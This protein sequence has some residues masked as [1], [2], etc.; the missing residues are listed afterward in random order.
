MSFFSIYDVIYLLLIFFI[1]INW[2]FS[3]N[4]SLTSD[5]DATKNKSKKS[6]KKRKKDGKSKKKSKKTKKSKHKKE[7]QKKKR[8]KQKKK[9]VSSSSSGSS[10][11]SSDSESSDN[12]DEVWIEKSKVHEFKKPDGTKSSKSKKHGS[13]DDGLDD[14]SQVGPSVRNT[15]SLSHKDF[16]HALL[17]GEGA[18][19]VRTRPISIKFQC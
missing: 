5:D 12:D 6:K 1:A 18:A 14:E 7:S 10:D 9:Q 15:S 3:F 4:F 19:M 2:L 13:K 17:P 16:G 8:K 11:D